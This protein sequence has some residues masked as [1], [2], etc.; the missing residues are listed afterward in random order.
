MLAEAN[1]KSM[2]VVFFS[3][4]L[5]P[6]EY[7][8]NVLGGGDEDF[9]LRL[10]S[11]YP[12]DNLCL[13]IDSRIST[14][15]KFRELSFEPII[16]RIYKT[17]QMRTGNYLAFF[18]SYA[19][20]NNVIEIFCERYP[21]INVLV[22]TPDMDEASRESFLSQFTSNSTETLLAFA[23]LGGVFSEGVDLKADRLIGV[24]V[25]G[26]GLPMI[27]EERNV[28]QNY[29]SKEMGKGFEYAYQFPGMNK[30]MQAVGRVIRCETDI[31][32]ALLIDNRF[33]S[34]EYKTLFPKEWSH[35]R[36][37]RGSSEIEDILEN[38]WKHKRGGNFGN[39]L[40]K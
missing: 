20:M 11:P 26:V 34:S 24:I 9:L 21:K 4:T 19:Y 17:I 40:I 38:F 27:T 29:Y 10:S 16:E 1:K 23:V 12:Q 28:V 36:Y 37:I 33:A 13:M 15:F 5:A 7:F 32:I 35:A 31:G 3:A 14:K 8:R 30:V 6:L 25:V 22:Q 39:K 2:A 18:S